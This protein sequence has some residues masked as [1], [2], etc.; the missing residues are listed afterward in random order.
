MTYDIIRTSYTCA[1][2]RSSTTWP[3]PGVNRSPAIRRKIDGVYGARQQIRQF[4][5]GRVWVVFALLCLVLASNALASAPSVY[6]AQSA[7]GSADGSSCAN[8]QAA[9][10]FNSSSNWGS[11]SAQIGPGTIVHLCGT[12]TFGAGTVG[13]TVKGSGASGNPITIV[14]E[15]GAVLQAP[16]FLWNAPGGNC[17]GDPCGGGLDIF[18]R[19]YITVNG[20][21]AGVIQNTANGS[22][23]ANR[24][25]S[26]GLFASGDHILIQNLTIQNIY[27]NTSAEST[28]QPGFSSGDIRVDDMATNVT[29]CNATLVGAHVGI[30]SDT[31]ESSYVN[32]PS[33]SCTETQAASGI[34]YYGNTISD[35]GW[36]ISANGSGYINIFGNTITNW[37]NWFYPTGGASYH[38]DGIIAFSDGSTIMQP[39]IYDNN[40]YGD[41]TNGSPTGFIFCTYG[42]T[43]TGSACTI[44]NNILN[45]TGAMATGN[46]ALIYFHGADGNP[47][48]PHRLYNN[49]FVNG[50]FSIDMDGDSTTSY[51]LANNLFLGTSNAVT[52]FTHQESAGQP[53]GTLSLD[54]NNAY[55]QGR[56]YGPWNWA[57]NTY[58]SLAAW[59][60]ACNCD[61][62]SQSISTSA[63]LKV[64]TTYQPQSGSPLVGAGTNLAHLGIPPLDNDAAG[65]VRSATGAW[66]VGA[67]AYGSGSTPA[68]TYTLSVVNGTGGGTFSAGATV[69]I[70]ANA[71]PS[72]TELSELDR[73]HGAEFQ[74]G[75]DHRH[76]AGVERHRDGKLHCADHVFSERDEWNRRGHLCAESGCPDCGRCP[77]CREGVPE[78][79]GS[80]VQSPTSPSTSLT[81][82]ASNATVVANYTATT[83]TLSVVNGT[84]GGAYAAGAVVT[85]TANAPPTGDV[86]SSWTGAAVQSSTSSTTTLTM[87]SS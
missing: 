83:Y 36:M 43:G 73:R 59:Q 35:H 75:D 42:G 45:G 32:G 39:Y 19:S 63:A 57:G 12:F 10:F 72:R 37:A 25:S 79:D 66:D 41:I 52:W 24:Q 26:V 5:G 8:A 65:V 51:S 64:N 22:S 31:S 74:R 14:F 28:S 80:T 30:W 87:P 3:S 62:A 67:F 34:N 13:L 40:I 77:T 38:L 23:L 68:T 49:T 48:G 20:Q 85:I 53:F 6:V 18:N 2:Q 56:A 50:G 21:N 76:H 82:P 78:L 33:S 81:M 55:A 4:T 46:S 17:N 29:I 58:T 60:S 15:Q 61:S 69:T 86:F 47:L 11:G 84:G 54:N 1:R 44:F 7:A 71:A 27:L 70:V 16:Y 9:A